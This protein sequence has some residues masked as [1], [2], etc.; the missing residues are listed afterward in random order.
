MRTPIPDTDKRVIGEPEIYHYK[1]LAA[2][3]VARCA[4]DYLL[5]LV[6]LR[7]DQSNRFKEIYKSASDKNYLTWRRVLEENRPKKHEM[8]MRI[9]ERKVEI[10]EF[11]D[12]KRE[13]KNSKRLAIGR[14]AEAQRLMA[15]EYE[16]PK[17]QKEHIEE[18]NHVIRQL[19][20]HMKHCDTEAGRL[21]AKIIKTY[22]K[23][24]VLRQD[25]GKLTEMEE[26]AKRNIRAS[27]IHRETVEGVQRRAE[28][29]ECWFNSPQF[30]ILAEIE[31]QALIDRAKKSVRKGRTC[32]LGEFW[33]VETMIQDHLQALKDKGIKPRQKRGRRKT[34]K[35]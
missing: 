4:E 15:K 3:I 18:G 27:S 30:H 16:D 28:A 6:Y 1:L 29:S 24:T 31:P 22:D 11:E 2:E 21:D 9:K 33:F 23:I 13:W 35:L 26:Y 12:K 14:I 19:E 34:P 5:C 17:R 10:A 20:K 32:E 7:D 8:R 25:I